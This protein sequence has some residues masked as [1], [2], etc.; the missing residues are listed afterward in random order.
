MTAY[1]IRWQWI[2]LKRQWL[3]FRT[4][5][6]L[7]VNILFQVVLVVSALADP[8]SYASTIPMFVAYSSI[9]ILIQTMNGFSQATAVS[10][11]GLLGAAPI[12]HRPKMAMVLFSLVV[13]AAINSGILALGLGLSL[14]IH[15][16]HLGAFLAMILIFITSLCLNAGIGAG[17][18]AW[19]SQW[20]P[21][22]LKHQTGVIISPFLFLL[23][24]AYSVMSQRDPQL[25]TR[26]GN[27]FISIAAHPS[28]AYPQINALLTA[29]FV[30]V[31]FAAIPFG[32]RF[33]VLSQ[34]PADVL[35]TDGRTYHYRPVPTGLLRLLFWRE[36]LIL[37][38]TKGLSM[39][40]GVL[41]LS[42]FAFFPGKL[43]NVAFIFLGI[44]A[45]ALLHSGTDLKSLPLIYLA[46]IRLDRF[47]L[48]RLLLLLP[49][50]IIQAG[51]FVAIL[52]LAHHE[53]LSLTTVLDDMM[54]DILGVIGAS[55]FS[56]FIYRH[57]Q[58]AKNH[59]LR[60]TGRVL[61]GTLLY[62]IIP[63]GVA[64]LNARLPLLG[65]S[66]DAILCLALLYFGPIYLRTNKSIQ[67]PLG[68]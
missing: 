60:L 38:R 48:R 59:K 53:T 7:G 12:A 26:T 1:L 63:F 5:I 65:F 2:I 54:L 52:Y 30:G 45:G 41:F 9:F 16:Y 3:D 34:R 56:F 32:R 35:S 55:F 19:A 21:T 64:F 40:F 27:F 50:S 33:S 66:F 14:F 47:W 28:Q 25:F 62:S 68:A 49:Q 13:T 67:Y 23:M 58:P 51:I 44:Q 20:L 18:S 42:T 15:G 11:L 4:A 29:A 39:L 22:R 17:L 8:Q 46:P 24:G 6:N 61:T 10:T 37:T 57:Q 43:N 31:L 36:W